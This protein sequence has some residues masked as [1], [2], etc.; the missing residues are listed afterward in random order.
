MTKIEKSLQA[1]L[2]HYHDTMV[3]MDICKFESKTLQLTFGESTR[4]ISIL[5]RDVEQISEDYA[6]VLE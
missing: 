4:W 3:N 6:Y 5:K 2:K 1:D